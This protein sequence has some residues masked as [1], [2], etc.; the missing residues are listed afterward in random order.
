MYLGYQTQKNGQEIHRQ[1]DVQRSLVYPSAS[2]LMESSALATDGDHSDKGLI[3][4]PTHD[5]VRALNNF[6]HYAPAIKS[7]QQRR[8]ADW[9][10]T[11]LFIDD[12]YEQHEDVERYEDEQLAHA[13]RDIIRYLIHDAGGMVDRVAMEKKEKQDLD[14]YMLERERMNEERLRNLE[15][16]SASIYLD[17]QVI[18]V[19]NRDQALVDTHI[20]DPVSVCVSTGAR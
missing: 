8:A 13:G 17:E 15:E 3:T 7:C 18:W 5:M 10:R 6:R 20:F 1:L 19:A 14:Q 2:P 11:Q 4:I 12:H 16:R 9:A